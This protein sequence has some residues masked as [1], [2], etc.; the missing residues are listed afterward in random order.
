MARAVS[1]PPEETL[2]ALG[3]ALAALRHA[4]GARAWVVGSTKHQAA[5]APE[6][7]ALLGALDPSPA[8]AVTRAVPPRPIERARERDATIRDDAFVALVNPSTANGA[9][10]NSRPIASFEAPS[11][12][13]L[14]DFL[15]A[16]VFGGTGAHS[17]YKRVWGAGLAYSGYVNAMPSR[18]RLLLYSDRV[19]D[20][21]QLLRFVSGEVKRATVDPRFVEY[22]L[23]R[24]FGSRA[25]DPYESR[26]R[27][28]AV[29]LAEGRTPERVR[30]FRERLLALRS[31]PGLAERLHDR[32]VPVL[33]P[34]L[35][36]LAPGA[37]V[38]SGTV[39][40]AVGPEAQIAAYE[41]ELRGTLG[42]SVHVARL[43]PRDFW[44][45]PD[46]GK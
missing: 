13:D 27:D 8:P 12:D 24:G 25:A 39:R 5:I 46:S 3:R 4:P 10:A 11:D 33:A 26:G 15:S 45:A 28:M 36:T 14:V 34:I 43:Y 23:A 41:R 7:D 20:L 16:N 22:A 30:A 40:F 18:G 1:R 6:L 38:P 32:L 35:P 42:E 17:F 19:A 29:D 44:D 21:P 31:R 37:A 2:D 9:L